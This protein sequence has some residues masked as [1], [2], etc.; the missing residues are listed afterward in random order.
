MH[1]S[2]TGLRLRDNAHINYWAEIA[3]TAHPNYWAE[4]A[5]HRTHQLLG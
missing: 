5:R 3:D 1:T 2:T 4:I